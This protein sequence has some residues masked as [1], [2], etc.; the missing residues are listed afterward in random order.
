MS[1]RYPHYVYYYE[2]VPRVFQANAENEAEAKSDFLDEFGECALF[3][4]VT[5]DPDASEQPPQ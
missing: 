5:T 1:C 4:F 2:L 3:R